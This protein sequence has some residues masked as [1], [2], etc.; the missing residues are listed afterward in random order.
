MIL[1]CS[2]GKTFSLSTQR[3]LYWTALRADRGLSPGGGMSET[4]M[5][6]ETLGVLESTGSE[7]ILILEADL[8]TI[9]LRGTCFCPGFLGLTIF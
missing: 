8:V 2:C 4:V 5:E 6:A 9:E 1:S 3:F 7:D